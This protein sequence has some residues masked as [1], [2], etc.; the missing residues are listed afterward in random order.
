MEQVFNEALDE[1]LSKHLNQF[2]NAFRE[3]ANN[4]ESVA[5]RTLVRDSSE[6]LTKD[7]GQLTEQLHSIQ[8]RVDYQIKTQANEINQYLQEIAELN[9]S[10]STAEMHGG[11]AN[12]ERDRRDLIIRKLGAIMSISHAENDRGQV[13]VSAK[14]GAILVSGFTAMKVKAIND[15]SSNGLVKLYYES[16]DNAKLIDITHEQKGGAL[17][18]IL[19][20]RDKV[21]GG[22]LDKL[23][24]MV[25]TL[26]LE[27]NKAHRLGFDR[28]SRVGQD[29]FDIPNQVEGAAANFRVS[30]EI[31]DDV[32]RIAVSSKENTPANNDIAHIITHLQHKKVMDDGNANIGDFYNGIV[33]QVGLLTQRAMR[34]EESQKNILS[35]LE[36]VRESISGVSLDE[37][38]TKMIEYQKS[39]A[40]SAK[41]IQ[42]A[43]EMFDTVLNLKR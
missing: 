15:P 22:F 21:V 13:A 6:L 14:G 8:G 29:F 35:Q 18:G 37:E 25:Y 11:H 42:T 19:K 5:A 16:Q 7:F 38:T 28:H 36:N 9:E 31:L 3:L 23:D 40:A 20:V 17:G 10:V 2:F 24:N 27:V 12:D 39:F 4:P 41:L 26:A 33:S 30:Q 34:T 1:G 43:D 32:G